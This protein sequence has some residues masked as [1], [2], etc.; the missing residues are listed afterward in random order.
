MQ[1]YSQHTH[2]HTYIYIYGERQTDRQTDEENIWRRRI[3]ESQI[4][5]WLFLT[6][7]VR[8]FA[9]SHINVDNDCLVS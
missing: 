9:L 6:G 3:N 8:Y 5:Q 2:T 7:S 1:G 4:R